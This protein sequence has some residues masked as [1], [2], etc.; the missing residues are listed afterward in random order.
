MHVHIVGI[1]GT[2]MGGVA[3]IARELG[4]TVTGSDK[5]VYPPMSDVLSAMGIRLIEGYDPSQLNP[6]P[7]CVIIG[8]AQSRGNPVVE[9]VLNK[10]IPYQSGP[11]WLAKHV[12]QN[13]HVLAV[14]GTH[15]K[16][17]TTAILTW[18]L[19]EA[20]LKPGYLIG[21][22]AKGFTN[23]AS[24]GKGEYF[25][26]EADEYDT[27]FFDKRSKFIHYHPRT[28]IFNNL[29]FDHAD[30]FADLEAIKIQFHHLLKT[31]PGS[32]LVIH[33]HNDPEVLDVL[34]RGC[35]SHSEAFGLQDGVWRAKKIS[36]DGSAF[37]L[38]HRDQRIGYIEW[39]MLGQHNVLNALAASAAAFNV[40]VSMPNI[41]KALSSFQGVKRRMEVWGKANGI[42]VYDD[43]AHHPTAIAVTLKGLRAHVGRQRII[44]VLQFGS[45]T[46]Q[47]GVHSKRALADAL[48]SADMVVMLQPEGKKWDA[49]QILSARSKVYDDVGSI[50]DDLTPQ[51]RSEDHVV[52]MSNKGFDGIHGRLLDRIRQL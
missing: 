24:L 17:T 48:S 5:N 37:E 14:S 49:K 31:V 38:W 50:V 29:E 30:I 18:I 10:G 34:S 13:R 27:A 15:G 36:D 22:V 28:L 33:P 52:I 12:L 4:H 39:C 32:G 25:V 7:D 46:M 11:E 16:T 42:T 8:N 3:M 6:K 21:G 19:Q 43:F 2:F 35:W 26:I 47:Q 9:A 44:A 51:L 1:C 45:N 41:V 23:T 20:G 40:G